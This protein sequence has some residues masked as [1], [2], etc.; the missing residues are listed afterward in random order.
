MLQTLQRRAL[1][2]C[3][4]AI[5]SLPLVLAVAAPASANARG[6]AAPEGEP[7]VESTLVETVG[8]AEVDPEGL[9]ELDVDEPAVHVGEGLEDEDSHEPQEIAVGETSPDGAEEGADAVVVG[10]SERLDLGE[11]QVS[12]L[13]VTWADEYPEVHVDVRVLR[14]GQ[15]AP[16]TP[17]EVEEVSGEEGSRG[18]TGPFVVV[19]AQEVQVRVLTVDGDQPADLR[20]TVVSVGAAPARVIDDESAVVEQ[21]THRGAAETTD[22]MHWSTRSSEAATTAAFAATESAVVSSAS[23]ITAP[24]PTI[25]SRSQWGAAPFTGGAPQEIELRGAVIH[26]T[27]SSNGYS[28]AQVPAMI[29]SIQ[30]YHVSGRDWS[31]IG[32]NFLVDR[33]GRIWEGRQGGVEKAIRGVHASEAN[34]VST[35]VSVIGNHD[36]ASVPAAVTT[37]VSRLVAWKLALHGVVVGSPMS[38][39]GRNLTNVIGHR[40]VPSAQTACPGRHLYALLPTIRARSAAMQT[41]R[42]VAFDRSISASGAQDLLVTGK[43]TSVVPLAP[44]PVWS[45]VKIGHGWG[46][47]D[48]VV[49]SPSLRGSVAPDLVAREARTGRLYAYHSNGRGGFAGRSLVGYGWGV[50]SQIV[51]PGDFNGDGHADI[52]AVERS[53][54]VLWLYPGDGR[55]GFG[56]KV[57]I[58][59][60]WGGVRAMAAGPDL[61]RDNRP[62]L[63]GVL[64]DGT[65]NVYPGNG[66]GGFLSA[67]RA[68][69]GHR[70]ADAVVLPGDVTFDSIPDIVVRN[71]SSGRMVTLA[72][73]GRGRTVAQT[74]WGT[75]WNAMP[76]LVSGYGW[77]A[78]GASGILAIARDGVM[79][80][81]DGKRSVSLSPAYVSAV[82]SS[83]VTEAVVVGDV[84]GSERADVVTRD[85]SGLLYLHETLSSGRISAG[86]QIGNGWNSMEQ[87]VAVGDVDFDGGPDLLA[88]HRDGRLL[89]YPMLP[90]GDGRFGSP[91]QVGQ[92]FASYTLVAAPA[93]N[94]DSGVAVLAIHRSTGA[95]RAFYA[96]G[97]ASLAGGATIGSGW[98]G[99]KDLVA[100]DDPVGSGRPGLLAR[101]P[102]GAAWIYLG[103]GN[104]R[105]DRRLTV[106][107]AA[108]PRTE[109][110]R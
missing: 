42:P 98:A 35:G 77:T 12:T 65:V 67:V 102:S 92:G 91:Y 26:H 105:F 61:T 8:I 6:A 53:T 82:D 99:F 90:D 43:T 39:N 21:S 29:K 59:Q 46:A 75:G 101:A 57:R 55:L 81:Y 19:E 73:D 41:L 13:G 3:T 28:S 48:L 88:R 7:S 11:G 44:E 89:V 107:M 25:Y 14:G 93:W 58:G 78:R 54:G 18:G 87:V 97:R 106:G 24:R 95:L 4:A 22:A 9:E 76:D 5:L 80:R 84:V 85:A 103:D 69:S 68:A 56:S 10:L 79:R 32:Y 96:R 17:L 62:D 50:M 27:V 52:V 34:G 40:D 108:V 51:A 66:R 70:D 36:T 100:L 45:G 33:F 110:I 74:A 31:D 16:W 38:L 63:V 30:A 86:R 72:G 1:A 23:P 94:P 60:G 37:A 2:S 47:M 64:A 15:W 104:G 71:A 20:L 49:A 83:R 109:A